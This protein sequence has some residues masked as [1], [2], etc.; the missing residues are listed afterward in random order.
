MREWRDERMFTIEFA[1]RHGQN[2]RLDTLERA[3]REVDRCTSSGSASRRK[4]NDSSE[5]GAAGFDRPPV[6]GLWQV[7]AERSIRQSS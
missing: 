5:Q 6:A 7:M 1:S 2:N 3:G 4:P